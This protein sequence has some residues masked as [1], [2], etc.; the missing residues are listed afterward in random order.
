MEIVIQINQL[1]KTSL[2]KIQNQ[3][4]N[5]LSDFKN[6][7][8]WVKTAFY[9]Q[10]LYIGN[11]LCDFLVPDLSQLRD[12]IVMLTKHYQLNYMSGV[13][14]NTSLDQH[15]RNIE[16][17]ASLTD[18]PLEVIIND[19]GLLHRLQKTSIKFTP[20]LGRLL[21]KQKRLI[22]PDLSEFSEKSI[23]LHRQTPLQ[24]QLISFLKKYQFKSAEIE[25]LPQGIDRPP[26]IALH[27]HYP[28]G[29]VSRQS[30]CETRLYQEKLDGLPHDTTT[31]C[32]KYCLQQQLT[33][34]K[35]YRSSIDIEQHG[36]TLLYNIN[37]IKK[38]TLSTSLNMLDRVIISSDP[39]R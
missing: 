30:R 18:N 21:Y 32:P 34:Q 11:S 35:Q 3:I 9:S 26:G 13:C 25:L 37:D 12:K 29:I 23:K 5:L 33:I 10:R 24:S 1:K 31:I 14:T 16:L 39:I 20:I 17:L 19:W 8:P 38:K 22:F 27:A 2:K 6:K 7:N 28:W 15:M 36:N 4:E